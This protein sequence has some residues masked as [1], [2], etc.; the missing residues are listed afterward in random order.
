MQEKRLLSAYPIYPD[1]WKAFPTKDSRTG[2][3]CE[4]LI[5]PSGL[6]AE[7]E[8]NSRKIAE[9]IKRSAPASKPM[10]IP[11][12][13]KAKLTLRELIKVVLPMT[14]WWNELGNLSIEERKK[15]LE[16]FQITLSKMEKSIRLPRWTKTEGLIDRITIDPTFEFAA[17]AVLPPRQDSGDAN[18]TIKADAAIRLFQPTL[19]RVCW[20][21][22]DSGIEVRGGGFGDP[23]K[24]DCRVDAIYDF[25]KLDKALSE[26]TDTEPLDNQTIFDYM[27]PS[28]AKKLAVKIASEPDKNADLSHGTAVSSLLAAD[29]SVGAVVGVCP[30]LRLIDIRVVSDD[31]KVHGWNVIAALSFVRYLNTQSDKRRIHGINISLQVAHD[32]REYACGATPICMEVN[33]TVANGLVVV[34][35]AGNLAYRRLTDEEGATAPQYFSMSIADPGNAEG[36]ITVGSTHRRDPHQYGVS[37]FSGRG[38]TGDGRRKPDLVAPGE[39]ITV[40]STTGGQV[41]NVDGTSYSAALVSGACAMLMARYPELVGRP[42]EVKRILKACAT[43]LGRREEF[44]GAGL[45]DV[46]RAMQWGGRADGLA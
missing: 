11:R 9:L 16:S 24:G 46:L 15:T 7:G 31:G 3:R 36:A 23:K 42:G 10:F 18:R 8:S 26:L 1:V 27:W 37:Y 14:V 19:E 45:L 30:D 22:I 32:V 34:S 25:G 40:L 17:V 35:A 28:L 39:K 4:L 21:V 20:A 43:D 38:P 12:W 33:R 13:V 6:A 44:Q 5:S 41:E 29:G 2:D